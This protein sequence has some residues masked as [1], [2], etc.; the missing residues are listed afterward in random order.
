LHNSFVISKKEKIHPFR[1]AL[2]LHFTNHIEVQEVTTGHL[3]DRNGVF[4]QV[5]SWTYEGLTQALNDAYR[6]YEYA[7]DCDDNRLKAGDDSWDNDYI[8]VFHE[9][10]LDIASSIW[11]NDGEVSGD[12]EMRDFYENLN[13]SLPNGLPKRYDNF[14]TIKGVAKFLGDTVYTVIVRHEI[15]GTRVVFFSLDHRYSGLTEALNDF[16]DVVRDDYLSTIIIAT[17]TSMKSF[18]KLLDIRPFYEKMLV[19]VEEKDD[20]MKHFDDMIK[21][22][23]DLKKKMEYT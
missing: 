8:S 21:K 11:R 17:A 2:H 6:N 14:K 23:T 22:V 12:S 18:P 19:N 13:N 4:N 20:L 1:A 3:L 9:Y 7:K 15:Y 16:S 10:G 5:F